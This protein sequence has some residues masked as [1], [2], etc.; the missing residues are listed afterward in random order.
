MRKK[1]EMLHAI[2]Q[3]EKQVWYDRHQWL[4][5]RIGKCI[6]DHTPL[7][8]ITRAKAEAAFLIERLYGV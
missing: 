7:E 4:M 6:D 1:R 8:I 2:E 5:R 3:L